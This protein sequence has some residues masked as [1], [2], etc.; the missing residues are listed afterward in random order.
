MASFTDLYPE[1]RGGLISPTTLQ[2]NHC[3]RHK[4]PLFSVTDRTWGLTLTSR[5]HKLP[6]ID[7]LPETDRIRGFTSAS[8]DLLRAAPGVQ[9]RRQECPTWSLYNV[10]FQKTFFISCSWVVLARDADGED[11]ACGSQGLWVPCGPQA[12]PGQ[13]LSSQIRVFEMWAARIVL[14]I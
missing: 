5:N 6:L 12:S 8:Q 7:Y 2:V 13:F 4:N 3:K 9:C 10:I 14:H 1:R 11:P